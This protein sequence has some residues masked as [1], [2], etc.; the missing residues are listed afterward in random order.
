MV[1]VEDGEHAA[2][3]HNAAKLHVPAQQCDVRDLCIQSLVRIEL[4]GFRGSG[5]IYRNIYRGINFP[6]YYRLVVDFRV[7]V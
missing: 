7:I 3:Q 4:S 6:L 2:A 5:N 1:V